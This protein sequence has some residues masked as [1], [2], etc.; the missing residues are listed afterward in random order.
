LV[1]T[2]TIAIAL[3]ELMHLRLLY[4]PRTVQ[5]A[6]IAAVASCA[7]SV[8]IGDVLARRSAVSRVGTLRGVTA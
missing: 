7:L 2:V 1:S 8:G 5:V 6:M 3:E 4:G